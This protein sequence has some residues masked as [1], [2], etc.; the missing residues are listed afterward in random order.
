MIMHV[1]RVVSIE[2]KGVLNINELMERG[3]RHTQPRWSRL[4]GKPPR[5]PSSAD[6]PSGQSSPRSMLTRYAVTALTCAV[7]QSLHGLGTS[8]GGGMF[9]ASASS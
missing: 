3:D 2:T 5:L 4:E 6:M 1:G 9:A 7:D 8:G